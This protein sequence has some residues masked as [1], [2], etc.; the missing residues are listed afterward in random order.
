MILPSS[1]HVRFSPTGRPRSMPRCSLTGSSFI[2]L[3]TYPD[4]RADLVGP[5]P[6]RVGL[7]HVP[8]RPRPRPTTWTPPGGWPS[9]W[10]ATIAELETR[11]AAQGPAAEAG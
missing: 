5:G 1:G 4:G 9:G 8:D 10:P 2:R 7:G 3:P 11:M 6:A